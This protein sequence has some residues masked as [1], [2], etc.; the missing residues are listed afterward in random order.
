MEK[1]NFWWI[2]NLQFKFWTKSILKQTKPT[3]QQQFCCRLVCFA[4]T[5]LR[6]FSYFP[7]FP[8]PLVLLCCVKIMIVSTKK[9]YRRAITRCF[10]CFSASFLFDHRHFYHITNSP[11]WPSNIKVTKTTVKVLTFFREFNPISAPNPFYVC[12]FPTLDRKWL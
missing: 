3:F 4:S 7:S 12:A 9:K 10:R 11:N 1:S 8:M 2:W 5:P 6:L